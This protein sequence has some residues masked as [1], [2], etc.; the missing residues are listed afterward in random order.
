M[1]KNPETYLFYNTNLTTNQ[2]K[3]TM[4]PHLIYVA[5][6]MIPKNWQVPES[7]TLRDCV[8]RIECIYNM[9]EQ[10]HYG[11]DRIERF[12]NIWKGCIEFE[13]TKS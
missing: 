1:P 11:E 5:N 12:V 10:I 9:K 13:K 8:K 7:P 3:K 4:V 6:N 2:Y